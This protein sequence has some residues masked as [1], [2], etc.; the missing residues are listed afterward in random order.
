[1]AVRGSTNFIFVFLQAIGTQEGMS[2]MRTILRLGIFLG[3][4]FATFLFLIAPVNACVGAGCAG[5]RNAGPALRTFS[6]PITASPNTRMKGFQYNPPA[7]A[8]SPHGSGYSTIY[9]YTPPAAAVSPYGRS[10]QAT[11]G[12][13]PASAAATV[14]GLGNACATRAGSCP[15]RRQIGTPCQCKDRQGQVFDGQARYIPQ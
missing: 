9:Q 2:M 6:K 11:G 15:M 10:G 8:V 13:Y 14:P 3:A 12:A 5:Q 4:V 1:M 7:A